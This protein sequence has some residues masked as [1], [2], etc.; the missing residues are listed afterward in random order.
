MWV[1]V[2]ATAMTVTLPVLASFIIEDL[3]ITRTQ[4]GAIGAVGGLLAAFSSPYA[5]RITDRI[6][7]RRAAFVVLIGSAAGAALVAL[8]PMYGA[9]F[10][11]IIVGAVTGAAGNPSTNKLIAHSLEPGGRGFVTGIKQTGPQVGSMLAGLLAPLGA[12]TLGWRPTLV[13]MALLLAAPAPALR[14]YVDETNMSRAAAESADGPLPAG[15][16]WVAVYGFLIG[17]GGS[18]PF[19][20]PLFVEE[21]LGET[22]AVAGLAAAVLGGV[23][24]VG[25][26]QW[27]RVVEDR[28]SPAPALIVLAVASIAAMALMLVSISNGTLFMW[29]GTVVL[30]LSASS[31]TAVGAMAVISLAGA[32]GAGRATGIVWLGFLAG[33]GIGPPVYGYAVDQTGSYALMWW[34]ALALFAVAAVV[35]L[36]W[37]RWDR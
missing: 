35:A 14:R 15:I 32:A 6:G 3:D 30:A 29:L 31:F 2:A 26:L 36:A 23:A 1:M 37:M 21:E 27:A 16:R 4:F 13:I 22:A 7:G 18:A 17:L 11:G 10:A 24:I 28:E 25:R 8:S 19:L 20:L 34:L 33:L 5:G 9:V 12:T